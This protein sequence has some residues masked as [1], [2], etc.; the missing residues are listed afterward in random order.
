[1]KSFT[2]S[3]EV[4]TSALI[5]DPAGFCTSVEVLEDPASFFMAFPEDNMK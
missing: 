3:F 5:F 2:L 4:S 1:V